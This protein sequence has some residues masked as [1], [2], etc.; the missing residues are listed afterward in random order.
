MANGTL[1]H[2]HCL[3]CIPSILSCLDLLV[4][5]LQRER[6][7]GRSRFRG[8]FGEYTSSVPSNSIAVGN[9]ADAE[10]GGDRSLIYGN[11]REL[12]FICHHIM[13]QRH[14][15]GGLSMVGQHYLISSQWSLPLQD[16]GIALPQ[17]NTFSFADKGILISEI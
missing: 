7:V 6:R 15:Q 16:A 17:N 10:R 2:S 4:R 1:G 13:V 11:E 9:V 8:H 12:E 14:P 5:G 3:P